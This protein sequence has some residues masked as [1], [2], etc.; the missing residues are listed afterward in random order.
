MTTPPGLINQFFYTLQSLAPVDLTT[1]GLVVVTCLLVS[2]LILNC[3]KKKVILNKTNA[4]MEK[5]ASYRLL[6]E[7][8]PISLSEHDLS[9]VKRHLD[10][11]MEGGIT[12]LGVYLDNNAD[13]IRALVEMGRIVDVN[14][15]TLSLFEADYEEKLTDLTAIIDSKDV[16]VGR[17]LFLSLLAHGQYEA[18]ITSRTVTGKK[19]QLEYRAVIAAGY[20]ANWEKVFVTLIDVTKEIRFKHEKRQ[21]EQHLQQNQRLEAIGSLVGGIAHDFNNLL[22]PILG[23]AEL[24]L[25]ET[26]SSATLREHSQG[27]IDASKRARDL[28]NQ[29]LLFSRQVEQEI[30]PVAIA[31]IL[32]EVIHLVRP[33]AP[34]SIEIITEDDCSSPM[35]MADETQIHQVIINL[36]TN[37]FHAMEEN[38]G[39]MCVKLEDITLG[40]HDLKGFTISPGRYLRFSIEDSGH[41][42]DRET[43]ANIFDPYFTTKPRGKGTGLGLSTVH[44]IIAG[45]GG[46]IRVYSEVGKGTIFNIYLPV[47]EVVEEKSSQPATPQSLAIGDEYIL[48]VDDEKSI[49]EVTKGMLERLGYRVTTRTSS[50]DA[51]DAFR[52]LSNEIDLLITDL[53]MPQL[54]GLQ[55]L[56]EVKSIRPDI[57]VIICTGFSE[58]F[59]S[60]KTVS[61]GVDAFLNKPVL[62]ADLAHCVRSVLDGVNDRAR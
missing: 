16:E 56:N 29:I 54:T 62:L 46:D 31:D 12:E 60:G 14:G 23:R 15:S 1:I 3:R 50:Y 58:Q 6:F 59:K 37:A 48:L 32:R 10:E 2:L 19:L 34:P 44:S 17:N 61:S 38:G 18:L 8:S 9:V 53:S 40:I 7:Q 57:K 26:E 25:T 21:F 5:E 55:L 52:S 35:V 27:I 20:E 24:M 36:V 33:S 39:R 30:K 28:V 4:L 43:M 42:I 11:L 41:G 22:A 13:S 45:Y 51:L 47:V 49:A